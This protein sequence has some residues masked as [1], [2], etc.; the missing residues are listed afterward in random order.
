M[1]VT[2][3][4]SADGSETECR[5]EPAT[6]NESAKR[7]YHLKS[8]FLS[9]YLSGKDKLRMWLFPPHILELLRYTGRVKSAAWISTLCLAIRLLISFS[10][11][12]PQTATAHL[13]SEQAKPKRPTAKERPPPKEVADAKA[14]GLV[15]VNTA[16][17]VY[18]REGPSYGTTKHGKFLTEDEAKKA[19]YRIAS[20]PGNKKAQRN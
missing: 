9:S 13:Q 16:T 10:A 5:I 7:P 8:A 3:F 12:G 11:L 2:K 15:W 14:K 17:H 6:H 19:G 18:H 1:P 4:H 20:E